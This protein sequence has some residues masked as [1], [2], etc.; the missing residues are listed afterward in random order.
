MFVLSLHVCLFVRKQELFS[1]LYPF[2][3]ESCPTGG[4]K[5]LKKAFLGPHFE[6]ACFALRSRI[7]VNFRSQ[8]FRVV[9]LTVLSP[10]VGVN[11]QV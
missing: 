3:D 5:A 4:K 1:H 9:H 8:E 6:T 2:R 10:I 11:E 7:K